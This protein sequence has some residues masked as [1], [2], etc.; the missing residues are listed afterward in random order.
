MP[1]T[2]DRSHVLRSGVAQRSA[3]AGRIGARILAA[4]LSV[5]VL[6]STGIG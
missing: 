3:N 6:V 1:T 4:L 2:D 5:S